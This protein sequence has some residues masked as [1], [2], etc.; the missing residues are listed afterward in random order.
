MIQKRITPD[1]VPG[2]WGTTGQWERDGLGRGLLSRLPAQA[3][4]AG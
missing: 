2:E 1:A 3:D 4:G